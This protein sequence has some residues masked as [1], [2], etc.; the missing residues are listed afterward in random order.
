MSNELDLVE[1]KPSIGALE[2][3]LIIIGQEEWVPFQFDKALEY[4]IIMKKY[5]KAR[6][7]NGSTWIRYPIGEHIISFMSYMNEDLEEEN[8]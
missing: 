1:N 3:S 4:L 7:W 2:I 8:D 5:P 6:V